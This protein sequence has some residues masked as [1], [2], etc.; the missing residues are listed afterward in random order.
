M[1][2]VATRG[3]PALRSTQI[4][5][6]ASS[7]LPIEWNSFAFHSFKIPALV[8]EIL[9]RTEHGNLGFIHRLFKGTT[10][11]LKLSNIRK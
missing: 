11:I 10:K 2:K 6:I 9:F 4:V 7:D 1:P 5:G 8:H 3:P